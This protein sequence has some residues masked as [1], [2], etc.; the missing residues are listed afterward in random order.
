[1]AIWNGVAMDLLTQVNVIVAAGVGSNRALAANYQNTG[2]TILVVDVTANAGTGGATT[3]SI[4]MG[5]TS[6]N[7]S[8]VKTMAIANT[9]V[10][11][12]HFVVPHGWYY[13]ANTT[14]G[15]PTLW[16]WTETQ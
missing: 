7:L 10:G 14:G 8:V 12:V 9:T 4:S 3:L 1:M 11:S 13:Q 5:N 2:S 6:S 16:Y 15:S